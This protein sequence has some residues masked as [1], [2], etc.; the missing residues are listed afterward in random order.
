MKVTIKRKRKYPKEI[1][2]H[3]TTQHNYVTPVNKTT[4]MSVH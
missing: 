3:I 1:G 4:P 2:L